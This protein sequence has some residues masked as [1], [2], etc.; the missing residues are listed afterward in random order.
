MSEP[1][2]LLESSAS[3][4]L[5]ELTDALLSQAKAGDDLSLIATA[6]GAYALARRMGWKPINLIYSPKTIAKYEKL[7]GIDFK[8]TCPDVGPQADKS[9][10]W[11]QLQE[12]RQN[13][14]LLWK[15][16]R[17]EIPVE[18]PRAARQDT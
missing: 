4:V 17:R 1:E 6:L 16:M 12:I 13:L 14:S 11:Y 9:F 10:A 7:I 15:Y 18:N 2:Q 5:D 8:K 3:P